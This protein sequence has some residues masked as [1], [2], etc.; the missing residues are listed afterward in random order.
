M[1]IVLLWTHNGADVMQRNDISFFPPLLNHSLI[2]ANPT[3]G[4]SGIYTCRA[5]IEDVLVEQSINVSV[6]AGN[7]LLYS[8]VVFCIY[9]ELNKS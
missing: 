2:I 9:I 1:E 8:S 3:A 5:A 6:I 7:T 4:D